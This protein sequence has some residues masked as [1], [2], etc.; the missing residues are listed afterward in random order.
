MSIRTPMQSVESRIFGGGDCVTGP[1]M[2]IAALAAG[3]RAARSI[4]KYIETG[5][6]AP[7]REDLDAAINGLT[8]PWTVAASPF[9][10]PSPRQHAPM[11]DPAVR[12]RDFS[13]VEGVLTAHQ[14]RAEAD[15]CLRCYR[16]AL[17]VFE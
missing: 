6:C 1:S 10:T 7:D 16:I 15:R 2:L 12:S 4:I 17:G 11:V 3:R 14:A 5:S 13:E 9:V 8:A